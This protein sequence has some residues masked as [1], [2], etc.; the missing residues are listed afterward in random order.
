MLA[1][2]NVRVGGKIVVCFVILLCC[3]VLCYAWSGR[4]SR[5]VRLCDEQQRDLTGFFVGRGC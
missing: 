2:D 4:V 3:V 5:R 1:A